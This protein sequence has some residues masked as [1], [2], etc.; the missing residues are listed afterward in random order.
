MYNYVEKLN[1]LEQSWCNL[2]VP[3]KLIIEY[4]LDGLKP[5]DKMLLDASAGGTIMN[6]SPVGVQ[7][8]IAEVAKNARF[9]EE[10]SRNE[11]F[12]RT[13]SVAKAE[14]PS[15]QVTE[16]LRQMREMMQKLIMKQ[17][18]QVKPCE[19]CG[20]TNHKTDA[21]PT[22][23]EDTQVNVNAG[24]YN[25]QNQY[26]QHR[27]N[28][29]QA[30]PSHQ[31][32]SKSLEDI[33]KEL[34]ASTQ[35][36][37]TT[38][39]Q[40]Q[41][42]TDRTLAELSKQMSILAQTVFEL[43]RHPGMLPSQTVPNPRGNIN[44]LAVADEP[45]AENEKNKSESVLTVPTIDISSTLMS[46]HN[47]PLTSEVDAVPT[48][49]NSKHDPSPSFSLQVRALN[50]L[51][52]ELEVKDE[53]EKSTV[54]FPLT[55]SQETPPGKCKDP[56][57]FTVT[58]GVGETLIHHC[59]IDLGAAINAMPYSLYCSPKLGP[60]KSPKLLVELGDKFCIRPVGLLEDLTLR[61]GDLVVPV[62]FNVLQMGDARDDD[63]PALILGR[64]FLFATKTKIDMGSGLLSLGDK[65][66]N[67]LFYEDA[68]RPC[69]KK[70]PNIVNTSYRGA[71]IPNPPDETDCAARPIAMIEVSSQT[72]DDVKVNPPD[73]WRAD[74]STPFHD[75]FGQ[76]E[77]V[78]E[79]KFDLTHPWDPNL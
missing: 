65:T 45:D 39:Q 25:N 24:G 21:C 66:S 23:Q 14:I 44:T 15:N 6:L 54:E 51:G 69:M 60:L 7:N 22:L 46:E 41:V 17:S 11:E 19:F 2:G 61:V 58:C 26:Q 34:A 57:A 37:V 52:N 13:R 72:W 5:L 79:S 55:T 43:K 20:A 63:P 18:V 42:K 67:F 70:P 56:G 75:G 9:R 76:I 31:S 48:I 27:K 74:T 16:E 4:L 29:N 32:S 36:I 38:V 64:P 47:A 68:D 40:N 62:D 33:V 71:F 12:S 1:A 53:P 10:A 8:M 78:A 77:E 3:E 28:Y 50:E 73:R 35:Q 30:G 49:E 59:L